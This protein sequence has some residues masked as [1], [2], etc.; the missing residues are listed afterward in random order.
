M[1]E[2]EVMKK[3]DTLITLMT[4][5]PADPKLDAIKD[6]EA[7]IRESLKD[8]FPKEKLDAW[9]FKQLQFAQE[10]DKQ[11]ILP[12]P[13]GKDDTVDESDPKLDPEQTK[14]KLDA[15]ANPF[16]Y[17]SRTYNKAVDF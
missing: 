9:D 8:K 17:P 12:E 3:L 5:K 13:I 6:A 4:P 1:T 16:K 14:E 11:R 10:V 2:E 7:I 15:E